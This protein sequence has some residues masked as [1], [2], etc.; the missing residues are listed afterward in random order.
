L[1]TP[2][3]GLEKPPSPLLGK[4]ENMMTILRTCW[5]NGEVCR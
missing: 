2:P 4:A 5:N 3:R 1:E